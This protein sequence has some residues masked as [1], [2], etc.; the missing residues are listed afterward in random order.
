MTNHTRKSATAFD[1][2]LHLLDEELAHLDLYQPLPIRA[3]GGYA[4]LKH[5]VR[6][7]ER[8]LTADIDTVTADYSTAVN[9]AIRSVAQ[10]MDLDADWINN[11]NIG[12]SDPEDIEAIYDAEW[13][14]LE[15]GLTNI[16]VSIGSI[17]MLT[18]SKIISADT[19]ELSAREQDAPDLLRLLEHQGI[20]SIAAFNAAYPDPFDEYPETGRLVA[21]HFRRQNRDRM[22]APNGDNDI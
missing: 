16:E 4:L 9:R 6:E 15:M 20:T 2:A 22:D 10:Q 13:L 11:A 5:G 18:R 1:E 14:V 7:N 21:E 19:A 3:I 17:P 12:F 8:A